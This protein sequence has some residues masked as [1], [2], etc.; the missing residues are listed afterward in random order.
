[1]KNV[2]VLAPVVF[3]KEILKSDAETR[4]LAF[5]VFCLLPARSKP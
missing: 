1:L 4:D 2:F 5:F 3:A